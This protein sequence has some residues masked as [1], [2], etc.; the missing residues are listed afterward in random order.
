MTTHCDVAIIGSG[1]VGSIL[2][3]ILA[4]HGRNV[5]LIDS[6]KHPRFAIGESSTPIA[7]F[8]LAHL[9][10]LHGLDPLVQLSKWGSWQRHYPQLACG[11]KRGFSYFDHR[12]GR[13][14]V[15]ES[16]VGQRSLLVAASPTDPS[17]DTHWYRADVDEF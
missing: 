11:K 15:R 16:F 4:K 8:L 13:R 6:A 2:A 3:S 5:V 14:E 9:G 7:D 10:Q 12:V 1:F 17:S